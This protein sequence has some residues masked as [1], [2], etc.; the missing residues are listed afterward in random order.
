MCDNENELRIYFLHVTVNKKN[1]FEHVIV[2][3]LHMTIN[4]TN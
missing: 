4:K 1:K 3:F 2:R